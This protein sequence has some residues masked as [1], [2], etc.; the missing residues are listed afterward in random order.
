MGSLP[1]FVELQAEAVDSAPGGGEPSL[2]GRDPAAQPRGSRG[3]FAQK[4]HLGEF[5]DLGG[6]QADETAE[7]LGQGSASGLSP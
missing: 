4:R 7:A 2:G 3:G 5:K 6:A 1:G